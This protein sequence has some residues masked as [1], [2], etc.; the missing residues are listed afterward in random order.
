VIAGNEATR[1]NGN[2]LHTI[3]LLFAAILLLLL[4]WLLLLL[5]SSACKPSNVE[6]YVLNSVYRGDIR[7]VVPF[8]GP[9]VVGVVIVGV[10]C[11]TGSSEV[12]ELKSSDSR[13]LKYKKQK[14]IFLTIIF[15]KLSVK[16]R[17]KIF[18]TNENICIF[19]VK[20]MYK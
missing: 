2:P 5:L 12:G 20:T 10:V 3:L 9:A 6:L 11:A 17:R 8:T 13:D 7:F 4:W 18:I 14:Y 15:T 19:Y 16:E 1:I